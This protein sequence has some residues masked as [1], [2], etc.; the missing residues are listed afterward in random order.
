MTRDQAIRR[1]RK[2]QAVAAAAGTE[3]EA[4]AAIRLAYRLR[5][6]HGV[7]NAD[8]DPLGPEPTAPMSARGAGSQA[9]APRP[10]GQPGIPRMP[11]Q[12]ELVELGIRALSDPHPGRVVRDFLLAALG[13]PPSVKP[14]SRAR[15]KGRR[16]MAGPRS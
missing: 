8:L 3:A 15:R 10:A 4:V 7:T 14:P 12:E 6:E 1:I 5:L 16:R 11:T 13:L 2:A 9:P